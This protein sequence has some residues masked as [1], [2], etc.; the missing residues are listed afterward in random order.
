[1]ENSN[2]QRDCKMGWNRGASEGETEVWCK[3]QK[4]ENI[5]FDNLSL[6]KLVQAN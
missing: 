4:Q 5:E 3:K 1:M 6:Q 2:F